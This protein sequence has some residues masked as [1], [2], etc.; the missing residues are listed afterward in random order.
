VDV[1]DP[2]SITNAKT[3]LKKLTSVSDSPKSTEDLTKML[4]DSWNA[5]PTS[6]PKPLY[7]PVSSWISNEETETEVLSI[8]FHRHK[9]NQFMPLKRHL[10]QD[11]R[12]LKGKCRHGTVV[13]VT[14]K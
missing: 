3:E 11:Y 13:L 1:E 5:I 6:I 10:L 4:V 12:L 9:E 7:T 8:S 14:G 2:A